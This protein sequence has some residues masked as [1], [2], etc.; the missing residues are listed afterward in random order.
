MTPK[1]ELFEVDS[2]EWYQLL[3]QQLQRGFVM[4]TLV[5]SGSDIEG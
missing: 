4:M 5:F 1:L 2:Y 3:K